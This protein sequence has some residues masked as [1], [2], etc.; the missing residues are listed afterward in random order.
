MCAMRN[1][2]AVPGAWQGWQ[3]ERQSN[4]P[5]LLVCISNNRV[6]FSCFACWSR[7]STW[8]LECITNSHSHTHSHLH[9]SAFE[10]LFY[11]ICR[12][13]GGTCT[14]F[15]C[16]WRVTCYYVYAEEPVE[17]YKH[18]HTTVLTRSEGTCVCVR[19][20]TTHAPLHDSPSLSMPPTESNLIRTSNFL[21]VPKKT[22]LFSV[23]S[24][25][26]P[27]TRRVFV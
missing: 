2:I 3:G 8:M 23:S 14:T 11:Y 21:I 5:R 24:P 9:V 19:V 15:Y 10:L 6:F 18:P 26:F 27:F 25:F 1:G 17:H 12:I 22:L 13:E 4:S 20:M 7:S 16:S